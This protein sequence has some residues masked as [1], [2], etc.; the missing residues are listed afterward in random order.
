M[1]VVRLS[2]PRTGRLYHQEMCSFSLEAESTPRSEGNISKKN[3]VT[4]PGIDPGTVR[5]VAQRLNHLSIYWTLFTGIFSIRHD[6][7]LERPDSASSN[8]LY[9]LYVQVNVH[10]D[11]LR[12]KQPTR[13]IKYPKFI[14]S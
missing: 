7:G 8:S 1:K 3:P 12:I 14:L 6:S 5:L 11:K 4:Q 10:L 2:A 13:C 9:R